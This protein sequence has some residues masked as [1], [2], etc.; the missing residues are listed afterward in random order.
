MT[1]LVRTTAVALCALL[2]APSVALGQA[3]RTLSPTALL[4]RTAALYSGARTLRAEFTQRTRNP[5]TSSETPS[6]GSYLQRG[7]GVF[8][9]NF[10]QPSGDRIVSD[11]RSLWIFVPSATP[12]QVIRMP[13][14]SNSVGS[15]DLVGQYFTAPASRY[16]VTDGGTGVLAGTTL[17][18][19]VMVPRT[20][21][22]LA[23]AVLWVVPTTGALKQLE[24]TETSG[25]VRTLTFTRIDRGVAL[26]ASTFTFTVPRGVTVVDQAALTRG[27][28]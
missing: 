10:T 2:I 25:V 8:A 4:T 26:P 28:S 23:R 15:V 20:E 12:G 17:R 3:A 9:V 6:A 18:K 7:P 11:G 21:T 5:I 13:V 24:A 22:G 14:A 1:Q 16:T 19:I 27:G